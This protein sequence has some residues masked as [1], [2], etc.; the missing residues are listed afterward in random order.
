M[1]PFKFL[2]AVLFILFIWSCI[3]CDWCNYYQVLNVS[4]RTGDLTFWMSAYASVSL[5]QADDQYKQAATSDDS[6]GLARSQS[7]TDISSSVGECL[8]D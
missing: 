6:T 1:W 4:S 8:D 7:Y 5:S 3:A 2:D